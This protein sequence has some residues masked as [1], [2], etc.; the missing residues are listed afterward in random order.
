M[1]YS[2]QLQCNDIFRTRASGPF[3]VHE[4]WAGDL[5]VGNKFGVWLYAHGHGRRIPESLSYASWCVE[6]RQMFPG[7]GADS[8]ALR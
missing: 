8:L 5:R 2:T 7:A 4:V 6:L 1:K 3:D